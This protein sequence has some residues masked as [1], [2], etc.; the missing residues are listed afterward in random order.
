MRGQVASRTAEVANLAARQHGVVSRRQLRELGFG[1]ATIDRWVRNAWLH[2]VFRGVY[3]V[4]HPRLTA[5]GRRMAA[6]L[7]CGSDAL[8]SHRTAADG[9]GILRSASARIEVTTTT[10]RG[11]HGITVHRV[12]D[13]HS[14]DRAMRDGI[15]LT[16]LARTLLDL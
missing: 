14:D 11:P 4:G 3:A 16:S 12:R 10:S 8:L 1:T 2:G 15:P 13:I 5:P 6:V 7:A 9:W